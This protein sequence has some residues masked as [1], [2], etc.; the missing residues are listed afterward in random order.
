V[1]I[2][3][4]ATV[5]GRT[6]RYLTGGAGWPVVL[7]HAFP[8]SADMWRAQL[9]AAPDGFRLIAPD[10]RGFGRSVAPAPHAAPTMDDFAGDVEGLLNILEI[11]RA[12]IGGMSMGGYV[13]FA[14]FRRA[15]D[16][17]SG[18]VL[19]DT[20]A[21]ADTPEGRQ[22]RRAMSELVRAKGPSAV[23][24]QMI[25]KLLGR[26]TREE[27]PSVAGEVRRLILANDAGGIDGGIHAMMTRPDSTPDLARIS[28][29]ALVVVGEE[30]ELTPVADSE[31]M[32]ASIGRSRL[33]VLPR[34][35]HLSGVEL[36][37]EFSRALGDFLTSNL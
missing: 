9:D 27:R 18:M 11:E 23:A 13:T 36:P 25:P 33:V 8:L 12:V 15:P 24:D 29:P 14:L 34:A 35:G 3:D 4:A 17:F 22:A 28:T 32:H 5:S 6:V 37:E 20:R 1:V 26:T 2:E 10:L 30:D 21:Q 7:L 19:A 16:R 31:A